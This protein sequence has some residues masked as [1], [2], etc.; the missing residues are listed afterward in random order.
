[1][2]P[3]E[4]SRRILLCVSGNSP[5]IITET[6]YALAVETGDRPPFVPTEIRV[7]TTS[8]GA[9]Q[10]R[11]SLLAADR[12]KLRELCQDY[13]LTGI[14]F[15]E[16]CIEVFKRTDGSPLEDIIT[17]DDNRDAADHITH[18]VAELTNDAQTAIHASIAGGR[19]T[20]GFYLG[21]AMSLFGREQDRVSHVLVSEGF[22]DHRDFF[23]KPKKPVTL[24]NA[25]GWEMSTADARIHLAEIPIVRLG[26]T[27]FG[28]VSDRKMGFADAVARANLLAAGTEFRIKV[29]QSLGRSAGR[30][31]V[32]LNGQPL[33]LQPSQVAFVHWLAQRRMTDANNGGDGHVSRNAFGYE[34]KNP[35]GLGYLN[36][37]LDLV[38][39]QYG[40][41]SDVTA[42]VRQSII[43][44]D[45]GGGT[46]ADPI[47]WL[48]DVIGGINRRIKA[49]FGT[50][51]IKRYGIVR[52][53]KR[54]DLKYRLAI[55]P[56]H[57]HLEE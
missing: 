26:S 44:E 49:A 2:Q 21:Y 47:Q 29:D 16:Q 18:L 7:L 43:G 46:C 32:T 8:R 31:I 41:M 13:G 19:K 48:D 36:E 53:G 51:G 3:H 22:T 11:L 25:Q 38:R 9:E 15:D 50:E 34:R 10:T 37:I 27:E 28:V 14:H 20:M 33:K 1:M 57:I 23:F 24:R 39:A 55:A 56:E 45:G 17:P 54:G 52:E 40:E 6:L 4:Y 42:K 5:Q 12:A 30:G 35:K